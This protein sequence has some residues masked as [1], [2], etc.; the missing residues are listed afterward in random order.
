MAAAGGV[1]V[2]ACARVLV[3]V[4]VVVAL[5]QVEVKADL[6]VMTDVTLGFGQALEQCR[7]EVSFTPGK[8][9][10]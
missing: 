5:A 7:E 6:G 1:E 10:A 3:A 9:W 4:A 8:Y 2:M